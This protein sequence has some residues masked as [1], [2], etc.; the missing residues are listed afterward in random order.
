MNHPPTRPRFPH[1]AVS[2]SPALRGLA[3]A[4]PVALLAGSCQQP[5][6]YRGQSFGKA[7]VESALLQW[8]GVA[9]ALDPG[10]AHEKGNHRFDRELPAPTRERIASNVEILER[11]RQDLLSIPEADLSP[12]ARAN[13]ALVLARVTSDWL[14]YAKVKPHE[15]QPLWAVQNVARALSSLE[16]DPSLDDAAQVAALSARLSAVPEYLDVARKNAR[17]VSEIHSELALELTEALLEHLDDSFFVMAGLKAGKSDMD[18][19]V[20]ARTAL[21]AHRNWL[22]DRVAVGPDGHHRVGTE[23]FEALAT[24]EFGAPLTVG[25]LTA[26]AEAELEDAR[27]RFFEAAKAAFPNCETADELQA[28]ALE[29]IDRG[30][31]IDAK[32]LPA[33]VDAALEAASTAIGGG[34]FGSVPSSFVIS[35]GD[36]ARDEARHGRADHAGLRVE[37]QVARAIRRGA[38]IAATET[39]SAGGFVNAEF[40]VSSPPSR[41]GMGSRSAWYRSL[42]PAR[43]ELLAYSEVAPGKAFA[44]A[45]QAGLSDPVRRVVSSRAFDLGWADYARRAAVAQY[46]PDH[47]RTLACAAEDVLAAARSL[48]AAQMHGGATASLADAMGLF[49]RRAFLDGEMSR[50]EAMRCAAEPVLALTIASRLE[51]EKIA[52]TLSERRALSKPTIH[53][54]ILQKGP[55]P[56]AVLRSLLIG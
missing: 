33:L 43:L 34:E 14:T 37:P 8:E 38:A 44:R 46:A 54:M 42:S 47:V 11:T 5:E 2:L 9:S 27:R 39:S 56:P 4:L 6:P 50:R 15:R 30:C 53:S 18:A 52:K 32:D 25:A 28:K 13:R 24:A 45:V 3:F 31:A 40:H 20:A 48:A 51:I 36:G 10:W 22:A 35:S 16:F 7:S 26:Q 41:F 55:L 23:V 49:R 19:L 21:E 12:D 17:L 1:P 29:A